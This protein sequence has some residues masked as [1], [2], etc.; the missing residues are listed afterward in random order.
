VAPGFIETELLDVMPGE[1]QTWGEEI[2]AM[3]RSGQPEEVASAVV[4]LAS[5]L[6]SYITGH[7]LAVD[8]GW[9]MAG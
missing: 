2:I 3:R 4:F 5:S 7:T 6:A 8:G 1:V 9:R